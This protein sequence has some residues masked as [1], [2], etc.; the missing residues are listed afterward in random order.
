MLLLGVGILS[1]FAARPA[2]AVANDGRDEV[3][4]AG[5][6]GSGAASELRLKRDHDGIELRF[7]VDTRA[8]AVWRVA[9]VH[10]RR[11]AWKGAAR[12]TRTNGSFEVRRTLPDLPGADAVTASAWGPRGLVCQSNGH[13]PRLLRHRKPG[14]NAQERGPQFVFGL[15]SSSRSSVAS[16]KEVGSSIG[17]MWVKTVL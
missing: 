11:I 5:D 16:S 12:T 6:C 3:R 9:L 1:L 10:E 7:R 17:S 2:A 8:G 15:D 14:L 4:A 13:A